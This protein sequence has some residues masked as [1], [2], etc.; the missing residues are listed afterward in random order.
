MDIKVCDKVQH[1]TTKEIG[2]VSRLSQLNS[3]TV[4]VIYDGF[5]YE[6]PQHKRN[7]IKL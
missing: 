1:I 6:Y 7:I 3:N 2:V 4:W 5:N